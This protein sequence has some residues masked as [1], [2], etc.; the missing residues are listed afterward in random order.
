MRIGRANAVPR[1]PLPAQA[2]APIPVA[3]PVARRSLLT[4]VLSG[5]IGAALPLCRTPRGPR[6]I[7]PWQRST[8][9]PVLTLSLT[10]RWADKRYWKG[11]CC[12]ASGASTRPRS[13]AT[14][15][16]SPCRQ[17]WTPYTRLKLGL[18]CPCFGSSPPRRPARPRGGGT[19][20][21]SLVS[22]TSGPLSLVNDRENLLS[23]C[24]GYWPPSM[25]ARLGFDGRRLPR[26]RM[27]PRIAAE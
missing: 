27:A 16:G 23:P 11:R 12:S 9:T 2:R 13:R 6:L 3:R 19:S 18:R 15:A 5:A 7:P 20:P 24:S 17:N 10:G 21:R 26:A 1:Q 14:R 4:G 25:T 8:R 22:V